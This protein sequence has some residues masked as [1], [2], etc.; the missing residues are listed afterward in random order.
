MNSTVRILFNEI[1]ISI[2]RLYFRTHAL[3]I[4]FATNL[5]PKINK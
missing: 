2:Y 1:F 4:I 5:I 3:E